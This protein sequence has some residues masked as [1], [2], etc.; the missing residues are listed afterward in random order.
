MVE[1]NWGKG[2]VESRSDVVKKDFWEE[3]EFGSN[4]KGLYN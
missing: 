4:C 2:R 3:V 1:G